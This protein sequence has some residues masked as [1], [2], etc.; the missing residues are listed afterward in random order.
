MPTIMTI[1]RPSS[2][3]FLQLPHFPGF[4]FFCFVTTESALRPTTVQVD[5]ANTFSNTVLG[6]CSY[7]MVQ[8]LLFCLFRLCNCPRPPNVEDLGML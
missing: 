1:Y 6:Q 8:F 4:F 5:E 7:A 2:M 3:T